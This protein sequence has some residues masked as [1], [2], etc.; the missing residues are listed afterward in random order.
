MPRFRDRPR[1][2]T[3]R[4]HF[5]YAVVMAARPWQWTKNVPVLVPVCVAGQPL[6]ADLFLVA[7]A[8]TACCL[9][10]SGIY[11]LNDVRDAPQD[12][13][14]PVKRQRPIAAGLLPAGP[15]L[16]TSAVLMAAG[17]AVAGPAR[18][19]VTAYLAV[20]V[21]YCLLLRNLVGLDL[22]AVAAGFGFRLVAGY[23]CVGAA[24]DLWLTGAVVVA[25]LLMAAGKR[26][27]EAVTQ[28]GAVTRRAL[29]RYRPAHLRSLIVATS[30][31]AAAIYTTGALGLFLDRG[32]LVPLLSAA[33]FTAALGRY[34][35]TA[36]AG[37]AGDVDQVVHRDRVLHALAATWC[38]LFVIGTL[39]S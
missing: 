38:G 12:R 28:G 4:T 33:P 18:P 39:M 19:A 23:L 13:A 2:Q 22:L 8:F 16:A 10:A 21:A 35:A 31:T 26:Y 1:S 14:H 29:A 25:A 34:A 37:R 9:S 27:G 7:A 24:P 6:T 36:L 17:V 11:L 20:A 15:A 30:C 32:E 5:F 3:T